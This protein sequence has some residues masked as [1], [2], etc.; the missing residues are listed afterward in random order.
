MAKG[1]CMKCKAKREMVDVKEVTM[2]NG[3]KANKGVCSSCNTN[4]FC[5]LKK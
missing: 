2:K 3:R 4:M 5:I 1:Y